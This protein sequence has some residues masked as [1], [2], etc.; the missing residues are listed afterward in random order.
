MLFNGQKKLILT[1]GGKSLDTTDLD[2]ALVSL[3]M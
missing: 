3:L 2:F 1:L